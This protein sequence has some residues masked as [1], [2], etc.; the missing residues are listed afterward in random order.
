MKATPGKVKTG[1]ENFRGCNRE[2]FR[3]CASQ[4]HAFNHEKFRGCNGFFNHEFF[5]GFLI[6]HPPLLF[7]REAGCPGLY[8]Y[9]PA[10]PAIKNEGV[11]TE[12]GVNQAISEL[13]L[14]WSKEP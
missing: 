5:T 13:Q 3:G 4:K 11:I 2:K 10:Y 9:D 7:S 12:N 6:Y 8:L 14:P 1:G